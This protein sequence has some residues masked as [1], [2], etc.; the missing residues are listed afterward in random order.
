MVGKTRPYCGCQTGVLAFKSLS[1]LAI[2]RIQV[3]FFPFD[4]IKSKGNLLAVRRPG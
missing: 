4:F 3:A 1:S 2:D